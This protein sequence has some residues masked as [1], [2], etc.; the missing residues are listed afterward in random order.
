MKSFL[1]AASSSVRKRPHCQTGSTDRKPLHRDVVQNEAQAGPIVWVAGNGEGKVPSWVG[2][3]VRDGVKTIDVIVDGEPV[4]AKFE[5]NAFYAE[6]APGH[7]ATA[8][9]ATMDDGSQRTVAI[10]PLG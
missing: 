7:K 10:G 1:L 2:G 4:P 5:N 6:I 3:L 9:V 8:I